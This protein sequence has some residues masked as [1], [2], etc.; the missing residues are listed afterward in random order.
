MAQRS[1]KTICS[2]PGCPEFTTGGRCEDHKRAAEQQRG[3]AAERGYSGVDWQS[4]RRAVLRR[5]RMCVICGTARSKVADHWPDSRRDLLA[6]S[7]EDP[8]APY[9]LRGL[10]R[11][12]H[13]R[14]T[15]REQ[16]GG[17][18]RRD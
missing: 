7:V 13:S 2:E 10:C 18:N 5:D 1:R 14:E 6:A 4:V 11:P 9:R 12:C 17:W 16:P 15:A 8:D 3:S